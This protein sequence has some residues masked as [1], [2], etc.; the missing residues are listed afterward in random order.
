M[1]FR[2][3]DPDALTEAQR[4]R[5]LIGSITPRPI[6][7]V[8]TRSPDG[9]DNLAPYSFYNA[10]GSTPM[11]L[12]FCP[13]HHPDGTPKDSLLNARPAADGGLGEFVVN[14]AVESYAR[15]VAAAAEE[16]PRGQSEFELVGL[17]PEP[18]RV[19]TPPRLKEAPLSFEC[20]TLKAFQADPSVP[21]SSWVVIGRVVHVWLRDDIAD[22]DGRV[23]ADAL[24]TIGRMGGREYTLTRERFKLHRGSVALEESLSF[25]PR[26]PAT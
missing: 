22:A 26:K 23:D 4:Y 14:V 11:T 2:H 7:F 17:T 18:S 9:R 24:A 15:E 12:L 21:E 10:I 13:G 1:K 20:R 3:L 6:A 25:E 19:V 16:L 5:I 8:S